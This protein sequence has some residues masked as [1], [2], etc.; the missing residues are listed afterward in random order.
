MKTTTIL[1]AASFALTGVIALVTGR[2]D[3][4]DGVAVWE[5]SG[6][7]YSPQ[8]AAVGT[9]SISLTRKEAGGNVRIDGKAT[10]AN[11]QEVPFW[12]EEEHATDSGKY[13]IRSSTGSGAGGCFA[14]EICQS[15]RQ[16]E[17]GHATASTIAVDSADKVRL[18]WTEYDHQQVVQYREAT[19]TKKP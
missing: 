5:G 8:G 14:N 6:T 1:A 10:L 16:S 19:L 11:G 3:A 18:Q 2:A 7:A 13:R 12:E 17:D 9:F 4:A 15:Y